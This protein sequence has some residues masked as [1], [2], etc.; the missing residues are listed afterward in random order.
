MIISFRN[1]IRSFSFAPY[2]VNKKHWLQCQVQCATQYHQ[3]STRPPLQNDKKLSYVQRM[4]ILM[5]MKEKNGLDETA[6]SKGKCLV[7]LKGDPLLDDNYSIAWVDNK[8]L[9]LKDVD[10]TDHAILLGVDDEGRL[11]FSL[12]IANLGKEVKKVAVDST[13]GN[14]TDFRLSLMM[15]PAEDAALVSKA[16]AVYTWH[17]KNT[18]CANCGAKSKRHSTG[19][20]RSCLA[21]G[22]VWYPSLSPVGIVLIADRSKKRLLLVRQG[23]HPKGMYSCI[24]GFVDLGK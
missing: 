24:A 11:Q 8:H 17:R 9:G 1:V 18:H 19:F 3:S 16:K 6:I 2:S 20:S 13:N 23:R 15:M 4:K 22:E 14:F 10:F 12:Q 7:Y 5:H 21:C